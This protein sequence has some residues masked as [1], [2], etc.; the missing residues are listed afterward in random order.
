MDVGVV[1]LRYAS[2]SALLS[3][4]SIPGDIAGW[5]ISSNEGSIEYLREENRVLREQRRR[6]AEKAKS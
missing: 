2:R 1:P 4:L 5:R 6:L 3:I